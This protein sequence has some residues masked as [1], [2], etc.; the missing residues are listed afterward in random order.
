[1]AANGRALPAMMVYAH[2]LGY[3]KSHVVRELTDQGFRPTAVRWVLTV[4]ALWT[5]QAKQFVREA[6]YMVHFRDHVSEKNFTS[7]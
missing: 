7:V 5:Q 6:A 3:L 4:P 2:T 1:M